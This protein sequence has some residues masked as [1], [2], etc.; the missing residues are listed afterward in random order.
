MRSPSPFEGILLTRPG[1]DGL[2]A[3][4]VYYLI[5]EVNVNWIKHWYLYHRV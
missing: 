5:A 2:N 1:F 4:L 3:S